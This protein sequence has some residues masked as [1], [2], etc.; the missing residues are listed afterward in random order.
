MRKPWNE[1]WDAKRNSLDLAMLRRAI[2]DGVALLH[3][4]VER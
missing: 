3:L 2:A 1:D 4:D